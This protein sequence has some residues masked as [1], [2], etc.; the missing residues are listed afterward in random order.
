MIATL[1]DLE[2]LGDVALISFVA[3]IGLVTAFSTAVLAYERAGRD[4]A[5]AA[6]WKAV[7]VVAAVACLA[8]VALG[9]WAMTQKS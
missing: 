9:A 6:P 8:I 1:V 2:A 4:G 5:P 7:L 3:S